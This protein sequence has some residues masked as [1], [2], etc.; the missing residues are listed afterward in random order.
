MNID[1][2]V[3][4][5]RAAV[6]RHCMEPGVY[7]RWLWNNPAGDRKLGV[8]EYG[9]ADAANILYTIGRFEGDP[10]TRERWIRTMQAMQSPETGLF[11]EATH[12][13]FHTTAHVSAALEL[14]DARPLY[15][16]KAMLPY[17]DRDRLY[18]FLEGLDWEKNPWSQSH[19][20]AG[21]FA[22]LTVT[23]AAGAQWQDWYFSWLRDRCDPVTGISYGARHGQD[24]LAHHLYGWFHYLFIH[25]YA[26]RP[27]P[28]PDK[29]I[30]SCLALYDQG[31]LDDSFGREC[32]FRE[33]DWVFCLNRATRQTP[34]RFDEAR[35]RL[36]RF[37]V[38][39][40]EYLT[41]VDPLRDEEFN[42]LHML[43]GAVCALAELQQALPGLITSTVPLKLVLD[44]R[45]FI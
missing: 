39:F 22:T 14:F 1:Q 33:I 15:P 29:M 6:E 25:E 7:S 35:E 19:Q 23:R 16:V 21:L 44:R 41:Q 32:N 31:L 43:F 40:V 26:R 30:D 17:L 2:L 28:Y 27:M 10:A 11:H 18:A 37:A 38:T 8:N 5:I 9:C 42:D 4:S 36:R 12:H 20:G 24:T 34:H 3:E 45:P 13:P